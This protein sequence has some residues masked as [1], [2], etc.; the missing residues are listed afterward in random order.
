MCRSGLRI[1]MES[2]LMIIMESKRP[3]QLGSPASELRA[4]HPAQ[5]VDR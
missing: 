5:C 3:M 1:I 4:L 2:N